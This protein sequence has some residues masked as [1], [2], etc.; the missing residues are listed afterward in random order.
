MS[1]LPS[2]TEP[3]GPT[4]PVGLEHVR[5]VA[6]AVLYEGYLLYPYRASSHKNQSR[7]QFGVLGPP[8]TSP[9]SF[10]E[11]PGMAVQCL[12]TD[13]GG[14][15]AA[16]TVHLRFLQLQVREV[17]RRD[18]DGS[19]TA[20]GALSVDG[21]SVLSWD[22]AVE[23]EVGLSAV[24]LAEPSDH[25][26]TIPGGEDTEPLSDTRGTPLG[27][28]VR[29]REPLTVRIRTRATVDGGF[30]RLSVTVDNEHAG[31]AVGKDAAIRASLI[32]SH[33]ILQAHGVRFVSLLDPPTEAAPAAAR[34]RQHRCW[35]VLAGAKGTAHTVLGAPIILYD[36]P[37]VAEQSAGALF[38]STEIDEILTLRVITMTE[39]EK[40]EARATDPRAREIIDRCEAMSSADLQQLHGLLRDPHA[41][42]S[43]PGPEAA[44]ASDL[45]DAEPAPFDTGGAPWWDPASDALVSPASDAVVI[46]GVRVA[47]G[48][49]VRVHPSRRAD[50][51]DLFFAGQ[52][53][54]VTAVLSD[55]DGAT[56]VALVLVDDPA[57]DLHDWYGR[58]FYFAPD[59]LEPLPVEGPP[60]P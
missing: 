24:P 46:D 51:Q 14:T 37:E 56:H 48:S 57:A 10:G 40:A 30:V 47:K 29:R 11:E 33:L 45:R 6:D 20:V 13:P 49:L 8:S 53:A 36:H 39:V 58:Y 4:D 32:G 26:Y 42:T 41:P 3:T 12:L 19:H 5:T 44:A 25:L 55:V 54:R 18:E 21:V 16:V 31:T 7:W 17:W 22:E 50:A 35:P 38:D 1:G 52:V 23:R 60:D 2:R 27:R 28:I 43:P 59:E 9:G 15:P 34:C